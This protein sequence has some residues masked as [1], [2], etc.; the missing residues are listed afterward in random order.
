M[1]GI[2]QDYSTQFGLYYQKLKSKEMF[3][4][5]AWLHKLAIRNT[6]DADLYFLEYTAKRKSSFKEFL[7]WLSS[8][9]PD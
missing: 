6:D 9:E 7:S 5:E 4:T 8:N 2:H 3:T 1:C